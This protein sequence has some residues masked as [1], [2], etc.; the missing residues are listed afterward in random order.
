M[1]WTDRSIS[2]IWLKVLIS[3]VAVVGIVI[4]IVF[5]SLRIDAITL[6]LATLAVLPWLSELIESAKFPGGW[7]VRFRDIREAGE[8]VTGAVTTSTSDA[9]VPT[10]A[11]VASLDP[12]LALVGLR[13]EIELRIKRLAERYFIDTH[14]RSALA[15]LDELRKRKLIPPAVALGVADLVIA[16]NDAAHG[17][18][19]EPQVAEWAMVSGPRVLGALDKLLQA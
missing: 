1:S 17:A 14:R 5:P 7:E 10:Y 18:K 16:G 12:N 4:R 13:I 19:V 15:L 2:L 6:G 9:P 3:I 8:N 11:T